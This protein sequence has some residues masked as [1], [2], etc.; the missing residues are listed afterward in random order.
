[1]K[2]KIASQES[3][4]AKYTCIKSISLSRSSCRHFAWKPITSSCDFLF[5]CEQYP[6]TASSLE[7]ITR[8]KLC[9]FERSISQVFFLML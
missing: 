7:D 9:I 5:E 6:E 2:V 1:M 8:S 4:V 3:V